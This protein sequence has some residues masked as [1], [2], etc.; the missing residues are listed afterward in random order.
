MSARDIR[1]E[2]CGFLQRW[3]IDGLQLMNSKWR[4]D[5]ER[6]SGSLPLHRISVELDVFYRRESLRIS[7][8]NLDRFEDSLPF[9]RTLTEHEHDRD[10][11]ER[12]TRNAFVVATVC[13]R[14][15]E[16]IPRITELFRYPTVVLSTLYHL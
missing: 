1:L 11:C 8:W 10:D 16:D 5:I 14:D 12:R 7:M 2:V 4:D 3:F 9:F 15:Y 13:G 6:S